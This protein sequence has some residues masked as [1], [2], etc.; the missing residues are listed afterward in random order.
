MTVLC[1]WSWTLC[2][3]FVEMLCVCYIY[4]SYT[5]FSIAHHLPLLNYRYSKIV[6]LQFFVHLSAFLNLLQVNTIVKAETLRT[7]YGQ[8]LNM[9]A[10][11]KPYGILIWK[12]YGLSG[13]NHIRAHMQPIRLNHNMEPIKII[14]VPYD[15]A[16]GVVIS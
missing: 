8:K 4:C 14:W 11:W 16:I 10:M 12:P 13:A 6:T 2:V 7:F 15:F 1:F 3:L 9:G 5:K